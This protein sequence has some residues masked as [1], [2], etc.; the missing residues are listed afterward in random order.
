MLCLVWVFTKLNTTP[1]NQCINDQ[2]NI[3]ENP[4]MPMT[5]VLNLTLDNKYF[6]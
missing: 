4:L 1:I 6:T 3:I 5:F 2:K